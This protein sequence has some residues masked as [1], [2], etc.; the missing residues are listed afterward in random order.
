MTARMAHPP[1]TELLARLST[2][3]DYSAI[4]PSALWAAKRL[5]LDN[6]A[7]MAGGAQLPQGRQTLEFFSRFGGSPESTLVSGK[8]RVP[9]PHAVYVNAYLA[10]LLDY[11]DTYSGHP[12]STIVPSALAQAERCHTSGRDLL[13]AVVT[14]YEVG[15]RI[16]DAIK[17]SRQRLKRVYGLSTW[18]IF[19]AA[20][21]AAKILGLNA[22]KT[23]HALALA[24]TNAPIPSCRKLGLERFDAHWMKNNYGWTAMGGT[25]AALMA[26]QGYVGDLTVFDGPTGFWIMASSD[27]Y[28]PAQLAREIG[29]RWAVE[30]TSL[31]P[32]AACRH[33]HPTLDAISRLISAHGIA[34]H[35][36]RQVDVTSFFELAETYNGFPQT[37]FTAPFCAPY[38]IALLLLGIPTGPDWFE[39]RHLADPRVKA[40]AGRV[41]F[42]HW[43]E[44]D[45]L[46]TR[47]KREL[48]SRVTIRTTSGSRF[49]AEVRIPKGDPRNPMSDHEVKDKFWN[50]V[51]PSLG[52][53]RTERLYT[54][55][56]HL[57]DMKDCANLV[58][59]LAGRR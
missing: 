32:Y 56:S 12:G 20:I 51:A 53:A 6:L 29:E 55:V 26:Q 5:V 46:Y 9:T 45:L 24:A 42:H 15:T 28:R 54:G 22:R 11:D 17:P 2:G 40:L 37:A 10:N 1:A 16:A 52:E 13:T 7:C 49:S 59:L 27:R 43:E 21:A 57:E 31:K 8:R 18:Q 25:L 4:P 33:I 36:V 41:K 58:R 44:A 3:I 48:I 50:L 14:A 30:R 19:S 39:A 34:A 47:V 35:D 38:V 23:S